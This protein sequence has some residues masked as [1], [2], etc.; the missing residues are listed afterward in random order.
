MSFPLFTNEVLKEN[1][2]GYIWGALRQKPV[3]SAFQCSTEWLI[4]MNAE[5]THNAHPATSENFS[6][7]IC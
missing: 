6:M 2:D 3:I 7:W 5:V 1:E 4:T